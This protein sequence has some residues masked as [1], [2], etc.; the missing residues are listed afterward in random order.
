MTTW[1]DVPDDHL[2]GMDNLPYGVFSTADD[3]TR[4]VGSAAV[5]KTP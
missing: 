5:L 1:L 3:P 2:F 4:R